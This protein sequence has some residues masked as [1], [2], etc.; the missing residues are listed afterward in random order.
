MEN[1]RATNSANNITIRSTG[2]DQ[3]DLQLIQ[4]E[5]STSLVVIIAYIIVIISGYQ[6]RYIILQRQRGID[7]TKFLHPTRLVIISNI[8]GLYTNLIF[9]NIAQTRLLE[10]ENSIAS[11]QSNLTTTPNVNITAGFSFSIIASLLKTVGAIQ[12]EQ[13]QAQITI[14]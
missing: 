12:R 5:I 10:V 7:A 14:L 3:L 9:R 2:N 13:E 11:G 4:T 1:T 6:D 8:L